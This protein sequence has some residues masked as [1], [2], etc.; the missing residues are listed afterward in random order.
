MIQR[1][2]PQGRAYYSGMAALIGS[3]GKGGRSLD[4][5]ILIRTADID[6]SGQVRISVGS[7]IVR[8]SEPMTEAA[9]SRAKAAGLIAALKKTSSPRASAATCKCVRHWPAAMPTSRTSG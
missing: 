3:D 8:H 5:A 6:N 4:S 2:E 1:Y 9:E 7:T